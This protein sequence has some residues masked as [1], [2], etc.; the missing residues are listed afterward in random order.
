MPIAGRR[1]GVPDGRSQPIRP[2]RPV[3]GRAAGQGRAGD[4]VHGPRRVPGDGA[5]GGQ[6]AELLR[7]VRRTRAGP[8]PVRAI[9]QGTGSSAA[10]AGRLLGRE[11]LRALPPATRR[12][13]ADGGK[14]AE[15]LRPVRRTGTRRDARE[16]ADRRGRRRRWRKRPRPR[17]RRHWLLRRGGSAS[18]GRA[19]RCWQRAGEPWLRRRCGDG[20]QRADLP[21]RHRSERH[22]RARDGAAVPQARND[23]RAVRQHHR[24]VRAGRRHRPGWTDPQNHG[25]RRSRRR[26]RDRRPGRA[27]RVRKA[28]RGWPAVL[29][30]TSEPPPRQR[31]QRVPTAPS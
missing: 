16:A 5:A 26:V 3:A 28:R 14:G 27:G 2:L 24:R 23:G 1:R 13:R 4:P 29:R 31:A 19:G 22:D 30:A 15:L 7:P 18:A 8:Q 21:E 20:P 12:G 9:P 11:P 17:Q 25:D 6:G 10:A